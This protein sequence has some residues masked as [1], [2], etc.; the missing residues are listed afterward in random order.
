MACG[1][2][3]RWPRSYCAVDLGRAAHGREF[4]HF[5]LRSGILRGSCMKNSGHDGW[6][7]GSRR[8]GGLNC[9]ENSVFKPTRNGPFRRS[10]CSRARVLVSVAGCRPSAA[11][12]GLLVRP[13]SGR[14]EPIDSSAPSAR[15]A[16]PPA[17]PT[18]HQLPGFR[19][20]H[21]ER[22]RPEKR[23]AIEIRARCADA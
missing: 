20:A 5:I 16:A 22:L 13:D 4:F 6:R 21:A 11:R 18:S 1:R 9:Q 10:F 23:T 15:R 17:P 12:L 8:V 14:G 19:P 2:S 7:P 3:G